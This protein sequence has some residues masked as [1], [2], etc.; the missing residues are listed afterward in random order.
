MSSILL[1]GLFLVGVST[2][3]R[4]PQKLDGYLK[5]AM[6]NSA[7]PMITINVVALPCYATTCTGLHLKWWGFILKILHA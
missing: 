5:L 1:L 6:A 4:T 3:I 2:G 7:S